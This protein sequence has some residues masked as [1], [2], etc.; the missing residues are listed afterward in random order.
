M[1]TAVI[2]STLF[3][4]LQP[5]APDTLTLEY[6]YSRV[7]NHYPLAR[8]IEVQKEITNLNKKIANTASYP[9]L[10]F[11]AS[12]T[13]QSEVTDL[14]FPSGGQVAAPDLSKD[15]YKV[16]MDISQSIYNGGAVDIRKNLEQVRGEQQQQNTKVE[17]HQLK[18]Q[19]NQ[20]YFVILL[21]R[22]QLEIVGTL[23][24]NLRS[25]LKSVRSGVQNGALLPSQQY[26]LEAEL[27]KSQQDS[28]GI[29]SNIRSGYGVLSRLIGEEVGMDIPLKVPHLGPVLQGE[30][31]LAY[32]RPEFDLFESNRRA[33]DYQKELAWTEKLPSLSAFGTAAYG[34]PGFNVFENDLHPYYIVGLRL[35][36]NFWASRNATDRRQVYNLQQKSI[37]EEERAFER[38]LKATLSKIRE[39]IQ[40]LEDQIAR[41]R[42]I[43]ELREKVVAEVSSQMKNGTATATEYI[44]ELNKA[45]RAR[46]AM[47]M[48][49]TKLAQAKV[50]YQTTLGISNN[51]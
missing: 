14:A 42:E 29:Q 51:R 36:W 50:D 3:A 12:A 44:S 34:R 2:F 10:N 49:K 21:S 25:Q 48:N 47:M 43:L 13:Y 7:E 33:L 4:G 39:Q 27:I 20:V 23:T 30:D 45:T 37:N 15:Q 1:L 6:C 35:E 18:E 19:I 5:E 8:K 40:S 26:I 11:G 24:E 28:A 41:D 17:L 46:L 16:T 32:N 38:Q 22:Q 9:Q 31:S